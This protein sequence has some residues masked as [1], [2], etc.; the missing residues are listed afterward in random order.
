[1]GAG[2]IWPAFRKAMFEPLSEALHRPVCQQNLRAHDRGALRA[3]LAPIEAE[4]DL[5]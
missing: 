3:A 5:R 4:L 1:M 2:T